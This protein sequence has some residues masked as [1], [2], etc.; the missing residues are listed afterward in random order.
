[1]N[2]PICPSF[3]KG[4]TT[5]CP[6]PRKGP[7]SISVVVYGTRTLVSEMESFRSHLSHSITAYF[8]L[9]DFLSIRLE[10]ALGSQVHHI[11]D[12]YDFWRRIATAMD[13]TEAENLRLID[14]RRPGTP[15]SAGSFPTAFKHGDQVLLKSWYLSDWIPR[16][17]GELWKSLTRIRG[18]IRDLYLRF[19]EDLVPMGF[20]EK[21]E[22]RFARANGEILMGGIPLYTFSG[23]ARLALAGLG[24]LRLPLQPNNT[25]YFACLGAVTAQ[26]W[27][28][29]LGI[30]VVVS[31]QVY[32]EFDRARLSR[33]VAVE[34]DLRGR[35]V[36]GSIPDEFAHT[37]RASTAQSYVPPDDLLRRPTDLPLAYVH[38]TTP[39]DCH[40]RSSS[41][42]PKC[43]AWTLFRCRGSADDSSN[44]EPSVETLLSGVGGYGLTF[45]QFQ[46]DVP[47]DVE[48]AIAF[49]RASPA[50]LHMIGAGSARWFERY[51]NSFVKKAKKLRIE[52]LTDFDGLV[53]RLRDARFRPAER[54]Q[55]SEQ[56]TKFIAGLQGDF[57]E[58]DQKIATVWMTSLAR[59]REDFLGD[60]ARGSA[61]HEALVVT[62]K[63]TGFLCDQCGKK[64][65]TAS[66]PD[67]SRHL[68]GEQTERL[69]RSKH[70]FLT[71]SNSLC[72]NCAVAHPELLRRFQHEEELYSLVLRDLDRRKSIS[73][74][75]LF[76][77]SACDTALTV[78]ARIIMNA[79]GAALALVKAGW[80][81]DGMKLFCPSCKQEYLGGAGPA[82]L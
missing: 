17:P 15:R 62:P 29:D 5:R 26:G 56:G 77:C 31:E 72:H 46:P 61:H 47:A 68:W 40:F 22:E 50:L 36:L 37:P 48:R 74:T 27:L 65:L 75:E 9:W 67:H 24:S 23:K 55:L 49:L 59:E 34:A 35:L 71:M 43:H 63:R 19:E 66:F 64:L 28:T 57:Q 76:H 8:R 11:A 20:R 58:F 12:E 69:L 79:W 78:Q 30:P 54:P 60:L 80:S 21:I 2:V 25:D 70:W 38:V 14:A 16:V 32:R 7:L 18:S 13:G 82:V 45:T 51:S 4:A 33:S 6:L 41:A 1:M 73:G 3:S 42:H 53:P 10:A 52:L 44:V 39:L 81:H